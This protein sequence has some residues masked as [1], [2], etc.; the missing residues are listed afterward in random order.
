MKFR[1]LAAFAL[2]SGASGAAFAQ[3]ADSLAAD[4]LPSVITPAPSAETASE[5]LE[6][7]WQRRD[8]WP[9]IGVRAHESA[10]RMISDDPGRDLLDVL[11]A[12]A[13][14]RRS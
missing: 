12:A 10:S 7:A 6:R 5:A 2:L 11:T 9:Q 3:N 8:Q 4:T 1:I 14:D 13:S